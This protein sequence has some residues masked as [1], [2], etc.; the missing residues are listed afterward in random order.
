[1]YFSSFSASRASDALLDSLLDDVV[2]DAGDKRVTRHVGGG[3]ASVDEPINGREV[4][5]LQGHRHPWEDGAPSQDDNGN[6]PR[7]R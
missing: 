3:H 5:N 7:G 6:Q 2:H 4:G 1:M